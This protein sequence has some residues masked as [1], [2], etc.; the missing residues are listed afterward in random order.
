M[1]YG[2]VPVQSLKLVLFAHSESHMN[3]CRLLTETQFLGLRSLYLLLVDYWPNIT[4]HHIRKECNVWDPV[5]LSS[6]RTGEWTLPPGLAAQLTRVTLD[7]SCFDEI[8]NARAFFALFGRAG[9]PGVMRIVP[10]RVVVNMEHSG[11][12][13]ALN[14]T[15]EAYL[16]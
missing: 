4:T 10:D 16:G 9:K 6:E 2:T 15:L 1:N 5:A 8:V 11:R 12:P 13:A 7:L 3:I 14:T